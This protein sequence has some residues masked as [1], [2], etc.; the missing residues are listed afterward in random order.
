MCRT[1]QKMSE[2]ALCRSKRDVEPDVCHLDVERFAP[3]VARSSPHTIQIGPT[4]K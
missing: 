4:P 1:R 3:S 2:A